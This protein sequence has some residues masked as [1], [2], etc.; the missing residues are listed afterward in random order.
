MSVPSVPLHAFGPDVLLVPLTHAVDLGA[1]TVWV[2]QVG[3]LDGP[4]LI[5]SSS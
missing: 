4:G 5:R 1:R 2:L 3:Q